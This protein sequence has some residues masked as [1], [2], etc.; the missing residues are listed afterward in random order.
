MRDAPGLSY[1][2]LNRILGR[3]GFE[4]EP[5]FPIPDNEPPNWSDT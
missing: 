4:P 1:V 3:P 5:D 2:N